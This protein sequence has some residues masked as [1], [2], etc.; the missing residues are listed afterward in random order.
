MNEAVCILEPKPVEP[1]TSPSVPV[2]SIVIPMRD[3]AENVVPLLS[4]CQREARKIGPFEIC[5]TNDGSEDATPDELLRFRRDHPEVHVSIITHMSPAGQS[6]AILHAVRA[7]RADIVCMLDGDGQN[8][9]DQIPQVLAPFLARQ[10][11]AR[12][13]LV[14]GQRTKRN[15]SVAKQLASRAANAIRSTLLRD[16]TRDTGCGLKAFRREAFLELP[17]FNHMHRFLPALFLRNNWQVAHVDVGHRPRMAG[18]S[19]YNNIGRA[20]VGVSDL[21]GVAW[22]IRRRC[23]LDSGQITLSHTKQ[24]KP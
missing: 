14:A 2:F 12:L 7:A 8:P 19:K 16:G 1:T 3:E 17:Y 18:Q 21:L 23:P 22:L 9:P 20:I 10:A 5:V 6:A 4:E 11:P 24:T 13:G 15:D